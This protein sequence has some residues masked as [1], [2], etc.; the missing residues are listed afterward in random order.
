KGAIKL[1]AWSKMKMAIGVGLAALLVGGAA[2]VAISK[3][4]NGS[5][6]AA[7]QIVK[8]TMGA[9]AALSS[10]SSSGTV[11]VNGGGPKTETTFNIRL[12]R[13]QLYHID[14]TQTGG[15]FTSKGATWNDGT[16]DYFQTSGAGGVEGKVQKEQSMELAIGSA[17]G[18]SS[19]AA[20][21]IPS[22][23]FNQGWGNML[24]TATAGSHQTKGKDEKIGDADCFVI[25]IELDTSRIPKQNGLA[26]KMISRMGKLKTIFWI[27]KQ[28]HFIRRTRTS[29]TMS[30]SSDV[31]MSDADLTEMLKAQNKPATSAAIAEL[32]AKMDAMMNNTG[33]AMKAGEII[34]TQT[35]ENIQVN[36]TFSAA[37][38]K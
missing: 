7:Q 20:S 18:V 4:A 3:T 30:G 1:M 23:F 16:G 2:T 19:Q 22:L 24:R 12:Q 34:F 29:M 11:V 17:T 38:F 14:W 15:E 26:G 10:Y 33:K 13:P 6:A 36:Q 28:D 32:R 31:L 37:D 27:G 25:T 5:D 35:H 21:M 8:D 9:Y